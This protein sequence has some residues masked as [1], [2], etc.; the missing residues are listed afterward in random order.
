MS[1]LSK[2]VL[3]YG[4]EAAL[5]EQVE[6]H[7]GPLSVL[8]EDGGL[9]FHEKAFECQGQIQSIPF[10]VAAPFSGART[11]SSFQRVVRRALG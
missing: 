7:A 3:Y 6:L 9:R 10:I 1:T 5:P 4:T 2:H 11:E 8:F